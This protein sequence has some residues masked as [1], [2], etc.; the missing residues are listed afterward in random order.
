M[1]MSWSLQ[2]LWSNIVTD[3]TVVEF[4]LADHSFECFPSASES[5]L[6]LAADKRGVLQNW[7]RLLFIAG[8]MRHYCLLR[9]VNPILGLVYSHIQTLRNRERTPFINFVRLT[10]R[11]RQRLWTPSINSVSLTSCTRARPKKEG[12]KSWQTIPSLSLP[13][14]CVC[15]CA[16]ARVHD[17]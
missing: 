11:Q 12:W 10:Y 2:M 7:K 3:L 8:R 4:F 1:I 13:S 15:V 17:N 6:S 9:F 16:R 14:L 5:S